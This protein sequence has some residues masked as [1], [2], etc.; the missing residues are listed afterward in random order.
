MNLQKTQ[1]LHEANELIHRST[2][3]TFINFIH[4]FNWIRDE[5]TINMQISNK[6]CR[7]S[8]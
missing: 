3:K 8:R 2:N 7:F 1:T 6:T 4:R 5:M